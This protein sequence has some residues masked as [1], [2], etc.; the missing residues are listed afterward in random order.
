MSNSSGICGEEVSIKDRHMT[1]AQ[2]K[3][4]PLG[5]GVC[6]PLVSEGVLA[7]HGQQGELQLPVCPLALQHPSVPP[8]LSPPQFQTFLSLTASPPRSR[9]RTCRWRER[10]QIK[11]LKGTEVWRELEMNN[12]KTVVLLCQVDFILC[13][14]R[15]LLCLALLPPRND[16]L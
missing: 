7:P 2:D 1:T 11:T 3:K 10:K 9:T 12:R 13:L 8:L 16:D 14:Q 4:P 15:G 6:L 5:F